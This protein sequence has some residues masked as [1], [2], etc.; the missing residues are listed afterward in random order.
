MGKSCPRLKSIS[1]NQIREFSSFQLAKPKCGAQGRILQSLI[2]LTQDKIEFLSEFCN[3]AVRFSV[4][5]GWPS[6]LS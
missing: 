4:Y 2:K 6:V 5:I 1:A 3:F